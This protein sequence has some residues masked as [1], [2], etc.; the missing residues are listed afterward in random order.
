MS[1][2]YFLY[3]SFI[4][5]IQIVTDNFANQKDIRISIIYKRIALSISLC[6]FFLH[7]KLLVY[8]TLGF[9]LPTK[10]GTSTA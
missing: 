1:I 8:D 4:Q 5:S 9:D 10:E 3:F 2:F 7:I 6:Y